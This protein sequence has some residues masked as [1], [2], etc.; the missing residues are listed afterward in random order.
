[1]APPLGA[2]GKANAMAIGRTIPL[3]SSPALVLVFLFVGC[4]PMEEADGAQDQVDEGIAQL[5]SELRADLDKSKLE[6]TADLRE[7]KQRTEK[8]I[9]RYDERLRTEKL[10]P[11]ERRA[12]EDARTEL[13][14][15]VAR[16]DATI[17]DVGLA[18]RDTWLEAKDAASE[19]SNDIK[20]WLKKEEEKIDQKTDADRDGDGH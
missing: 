13:R 14:T 17:S 18:T 15:Q 1:M 6:L 3:F 16:I 19:V 11:A 7:L 9:M 12:L 4:T 8:E 20:A 5:D 10:T 2:S